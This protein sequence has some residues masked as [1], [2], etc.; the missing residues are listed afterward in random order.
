MV[1]ALLVVAACA[2]DRPSV[3]DETSSTSEQGPSA[4]DCTPAAENLAMCRVANATS[5]YPAYSAS[6]TVDGRLDT[7]CYAAAGACPA[8][9]CPD[10]GRRRER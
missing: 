8:G 3:A 6:D 4:D 10:A 1:V 7:S 5:T 9:L 2:G